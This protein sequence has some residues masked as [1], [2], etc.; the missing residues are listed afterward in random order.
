MA[1]RGALLGTAVAAF[2]A[3]TVA[4][5]ALADRIPIAMWIG[6]TGPA[7]DLITAF[8]DEFNAA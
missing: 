3:G 6:V 2:L 5:P 4:A 7:Q 1:T 8:G